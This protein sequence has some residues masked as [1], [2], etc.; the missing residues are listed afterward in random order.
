MKTLVAIPCGDMIHT[1]FMRACMSLEIVGDVQFT[2]AQGSLI[3][4][5][6]NHLSAIAVDGGFDRVLWLD[7]DMVFPPDLLKRLSADM[8][9]GRELVSGLYFSR[10]RPIHSVA[11]SA[12]Y[13]DSDNVPHA[14]A[15]TEWPNEI[16]QIAACGFGAVLCSVDLI[17]RIRDKFR[18]PFSPASGFGEDWS[19]CLRAGELGV[20]LW[21]DPTIRIGHVGLAVYTA[22]VFRVEMGAKNDNK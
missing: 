3:Y 22:D 10:K 7:S 2:F 4:D 19:F 5:A 13:V 9:E 8:D 20:P 14:E 15:I 16:F 11:Y 6:R 18:L 21:C 1:D 12:V 17:R